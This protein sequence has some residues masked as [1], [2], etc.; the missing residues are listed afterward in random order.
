[1][2]ESSSW[3]LTLRVCQS[4]RLLGFWGLGIWQSSWTLEDLL[5][6]TGFMLLVL[7]LGSLPDSC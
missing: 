2:V 4:S 6:L 3:V 1:M 7:V 5:T